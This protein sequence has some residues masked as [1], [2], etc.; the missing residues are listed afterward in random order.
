MRNLNIDQFGY[1]IYL[2]SSSGNTL[3]G[4]TASGTELQAFSLNSSNNNEIA[5]NSLL[6]NNGD[7]VR[8]ESSDGNKLSGNTFA[9]NGGYGVVVSVSD[10]NTFHGN[11]I[12]NNSLDGVRVKSSGFTELTNNSI[13]GQNAAA[14]VYIFQSGNSA[15]VGNTFSA[16]GTGLRLEG[17]S[18]NDIHNNNFITN[19]IQ[20]VV[21]GGAGNAFD[22]AVPFGGN[23]WDDYDSPA[24]GC[25]NTSGDNF[26]DSPFLFAGGRDDLPW[27]VYDGWADT[28]PPAVTGVFPGCTIYSGFTTISIDYSDD[29]LGVDTAS[30]NI[31]LDGTPLSGCTIGA[32]NASCPAG[33]LAPGA[34][35]SIGGS[36]ADYAGN[37][38][39]IS[40]TFTVQELHLNTNSVYWYSLAE[41]QAAV[42][43]VDFAISTDDPH[44]GDIS[45]SGV[46]STDGV[47][48]YLLPQS[49][50]GRNFSIKYQVDSGI[51]EFS[52]SVYVSAEDGCGNPHAY[53]GPWPG[54]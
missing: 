2:D 30:V 35:Y 27:T 44:L 12:S 40:G 8:L 18:N 43:T 36:V 37:S 28:V 29:G 10:N 53:P 11:D 34:P 7:A 15:V 1:G 9:N 23:Y 14:G 50:T 4:N 5:G 13:N 26:C 54:P 41:Y 51:H 31:T 6:A 48:P 16:N 46:V 49:P 38:S 22:T 52:T 32:G 25:N 3:T 21:T 20:A 39:P 17:S 47:M 42:L 33:G 19:A 24:E 45:L